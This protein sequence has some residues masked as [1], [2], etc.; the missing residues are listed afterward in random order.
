MYPGMAARLVGPDGSE[1]ER[2]EQG[3]LC[4]AGDQVMTGYFQDPEKTA[5]AFI[6]LAGGDGVRRFYRTGDLCFYNDL[7]NLAYCGRLDSQVKV[8]G[9]RVELGEI[10][11]FAREFVGHAFVAAL[12]AQAGTAGDSIALFVQGS[13][14]D[15]EGLEDL[16]AAQLPSYMVPRQIRAIE[17]MPLNLNGKI[18]RVELRRRLE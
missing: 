13:E 6:E 15:L 14:E 17:E 1:V 5:E 16:L 8:Q 4:I 18:D 11:H 12:L 3:E 7:G 10:E 9:H 2:G